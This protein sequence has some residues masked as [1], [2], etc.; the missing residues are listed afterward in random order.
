MSDLFH[1]RVPDAFI[2]DVFDVMAQAHWHKFQI[3]TKRSARLRTLAPH[4]HWPENVWMGVSVEDERYVDRIDD[5]RSVPAAVRFL[6]LEPLLGPLPHLDL[7]GI[8]WAIVGGESGP[9]ARPIEVEWVREIRNQC[10]EQRVAFFFKQWGGVRKKA[11]GRMLDGRTW[12]E[13]PQV[14]GVADEPRRAMR[15]RTRTEGERQ[16]PVAGQ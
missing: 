13:L 4:L 10:L 8:H 6:S 12:D 2:R 11:T 14:A 9:G 1:E 16:L 15:V 3:L 5:L 7:A